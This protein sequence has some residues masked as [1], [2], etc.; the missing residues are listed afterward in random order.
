MILKLLYYISVN[1]DINE[2]LKLLK[3]E[4]NLK[5]LY[6]KKIQKL[7]IKRSVRNIKR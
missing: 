3:K 2:Y 1:K 6:S 5:M 4:G 7:K